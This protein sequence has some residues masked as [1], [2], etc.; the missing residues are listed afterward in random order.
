MRIAL[1]EPLREAQEAVAVLL[2]EQ[3][4]EV[5]SFPDANEALKELKSD[6]AIDALIVGAK[7]G[8]L[9]GMELCREARRLADDAKR[10]LY[11]LLMVPVRRGANKGRGIRLRRGRYYRQTPA[12]RRASRKAACRPADDRA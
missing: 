10:P 8:A 11:V 5:L 12:P 4:H 9:S 2:G 6:P 7:A 1:V 3:G